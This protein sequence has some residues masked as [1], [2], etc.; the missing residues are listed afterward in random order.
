MLLLKMMMLGVGLWMLSVMVRRLCM[1]R[2]RLVNRLIVRIVWLIVSS[3]M[4]VLISPLWLICSP[5]LIR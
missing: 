5:G 4:T 1:D 2:R 3:I